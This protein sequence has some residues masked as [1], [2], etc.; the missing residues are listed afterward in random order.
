MLGWKLHASILL[1][2]SLEDMDAQKT[3]GSRRIL[4]AAG[5]VLLLA[6]M[7][8]QLAL[9]ARRQS[10]TFDEG[11][12][13]FSGY[14]YWKN[15][16]FGFNP[17]HPPLVKLVAALPLLRL[18]LVTPFIPDADFKMME[19]R[20]GRDFLYGNDATAILFRT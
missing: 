4:V 10:Q 18:P 1:L 17:E 11:A 13:I 12:H 7:A 3:K 8:A 5:V 2:R 19:F 16:D 6:A 9:S 20:T 15:F 14:R